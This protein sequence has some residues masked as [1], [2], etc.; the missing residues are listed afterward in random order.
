MKIQ[1]IRIDGYKNINNIDIEFEKIIALVAVNNY[2]KSNVLEAID[3][4]N[5]FIKDTA[6][7]KEMMMY[8]RNAIPINTELLNKKFRFEIEYITNNK[9]KEVCVQYGFEFKW[10]KIDKD[11]EIIEEPG[12]VGEFLKIKLNDKGQKYNMHISRDNEKS[13][14][15]SADSGR[16]DKVIKIEDTNLIL[17]KLSY[18]DDL[19]YLDVISELNNLK[20]DINSFLDAEDAFEVNPIKFKNKS[21]YELEPS[22]R[23]IAEIVFNL[24]NNDKDDYDLLIGTFQ[25]LF[26]NIEDIQTVKASIRVGNRKEIKLPEDA[27]FDIVENIYRITVKEKMNHKYMDFKNLSN[28]A[29]RIF[30]FLT[31][32]ILANKQK[33]PLIAFEE[34]E[35]CINP[36]LFEELITSVGQIAED[37]NVIISSHSPIL[38][39]CLEMSSIYMGMPSDKGIAEFKRIKKSKY[40]ALEND[41]RQANEGVGDYLFEALRDYSEQDYLSQ[42]LE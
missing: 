39:N 8:Y 35:N 42:Y 27:P 9:D 14:Y 4:A 25:G 2:G 28:G 22:G 21:I 5:R 7:G 30:L 19:F 36:K 16:C 41:A 29:K 38:I 32:L 18:Y 11:E 1:R 34:L 37:C 33:R 13:M 31:S 20:F 6:E 40:K 17:N 10:P 12:I 23:N 24:E 3:F 26:R 15:K